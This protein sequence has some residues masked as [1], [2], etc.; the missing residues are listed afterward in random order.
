MAGT[1]AQPQPKHLTSRHVRV[2]TH[3]ASW[4]QLI[5]EDINVDRNEHIKVGHG[6][7]RRAFAKGQRVSKQANYQ[8]SYPNVMPDIN[9]RMASFVRFDSFLQLG[10]SPALNSFW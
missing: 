5:F 1:S 2:P 8:H 3:M 10:S 7:L 9:R 4:V 6:G